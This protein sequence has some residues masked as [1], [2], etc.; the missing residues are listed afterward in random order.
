MSTTALPEADLAARQPG[1]VAVA[2][3]HRRLAEWARDNRL[4]SAAL[5]VAAL[6]RILVAVAYT[7]ALAFYGDSYAYLG[8]ARQPLTLS[9][10]HPSGYPILVW[11]TSLTHSVAVLTTLQH[12]LGLATALLLYQLVR[13][14]G[15]GSLGGTLA[16][17][18]VLFDAY[19]LDIEQ[20]VLSDAVFTFLVVLTMPLTVR[21]LRD[22]GWER[23][24]VL[25]GV[26]GVATL[27]RSVGLVVAVA[28]LVVIAVA[29]AGWRTV[30]T[31]AAACAV[32]V[33]GYALAFQATY[34]VL[35]LEGYGGRYLYGTVAPFASCQPLSLPRKERGLCPQLPRYARP[36][37]NQYV[38]SE[39]GLADLRGSAI[40]QSQTAGQFAR[41]IALH[42]P[43]QFA[44][45]V[46][47]NFAHYFEPGRESGTRDWFV[48][49]WQF[50]LRVH[51]PAWHVQPLSVGF[52]PKDHV[53]GRIIVG[54]AR[55]LRRY[56]RVFFTPGPLLLLCILGTAAACLLRR[57]DVEVRR[58]SALL[59]S[60]GL[61]LLIVPSVSAGFDWR[62]LIPAQ[63]VIGAG[64]VLAAT[65]LRTPL[66]RLLRSAFP[67]VVVLVGLALVVPGLFYS[68]VYA[69]SALHARRVVDVPASVSLGGHATVTIGDATLLSTRCRATRGAR[70]IVGLVAFPASLTYAS[71]PSMLVQA[72]NAD[73]SNGYLT[74]PH[75]YPGGS[76]LANAVLSKRF[77]VVS[78]TLYALVRTPAGVLR[79]VDPL[80]AGAAAFRFRLV[81]PPGQLPV[82]QRCTGPS[83]WAGAQLKQLRFTDLPPFTDGTQQQLQYGVIGQATRA[84]SYDL[85][86]RV[87]TATAPAGAWQYPKAWQAT[88]SQ[89]QSLVDLAPGVT[90]CF[91]VRARDALGVA[92]DW[93][94]P[95][96]TAR[97]YDDTSL[98]RAVGWI[99]VSGQTGFYLD[100]Y[101]VAKARGATVT[102]A[103]TFSRVAV[104]AYRCPTCGVVNIYVGPRLVRTLDLTATS[105]DAGPVEWTSPTV[106]TET[107]TLTLKVASNDRPVAIDG[108]GLLR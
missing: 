73:L 74:F 42:Q 84:T 32:P 77:P 98:P 30:A 27:T 75:A 34:G 99:Q 82:G 81:T 107:S 20:F 14:L 46:A 62:Y 26:L 54:L 104:R 56:Q 44:G 97:L 25:G 38:W 10:W 72:T 48:G 59:G 53:R 64:G 24:C 8:A 45:V 51:A 12:L 15:V 91:S 29:R 70:R 71:G 19:Q 67:A 87:A 76:P 57:H 40:Q 79:Y 9:L 89:Q 102:V 83:V 6:L 61:L 36:G 17:A 21:L 80:G 94:S 23:A 43:A 86:F 16:A 41:T 33:F 3:V 11:L 63:A 1:G 35:G 92:T 55:L 68:S 65:T 69:E 60:T 49:S 100:T 90:Y 101:T 18:P 47:A 96:C 88:A 78:G 66:Q 4:F 105:A 58:T 103:G 108:F 5:V 50:P 95:Q 52:Q 85:R 93:S 7:P 39:Y 106:P 37:F 2:P 13:R 28:V 31:V 22:P